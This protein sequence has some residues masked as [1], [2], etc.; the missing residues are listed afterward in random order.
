MILR[1]PSICF[2]KKKN[3]NYVHK[4]WSEGVFQLSFGGILVHMEPL[5]D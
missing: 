1:F 4:L 5:K 3:H 2:Q